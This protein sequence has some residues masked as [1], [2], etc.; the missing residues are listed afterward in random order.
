MSNPAGNSEQGAAS[1]ERQLSERT[2]ERDEARL[3]MAFRCSTG[4]INLCRADV[5]PFTDRQIGLVQCFAVQG[6]GPALSMSHD[7]IVRQHAGMIEVDTEPGEL[8]EFTLKLPLMSK[9][10]SKSR[11]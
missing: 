11:G 5:K 6:T 2:A 7:I 4:I 1:L 9:L 8:T 10:S 3:P